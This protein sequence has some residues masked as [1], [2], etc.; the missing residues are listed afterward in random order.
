MIVHRLVLAAICV[1]PVIPVASPTP[2][3]PIVASFMY[4]CEAD[5][6]RPSLT[7]RYTGEGRSQRREATATVE[8][9]ERGHDP[10]RSFR[11]IGEV[12]VRANSARTSTVELRRCAERGARELGGD[13]LV[14]LVIDD[15]AALHAGPVGL[16]CATARVVQ[17]R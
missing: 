5:E 3:A 7:M 16:L 17:W 13:A 1:L 6:P 11:A 4:A 12:R 8:V 14:D 2:G 10:A 9:F 15:A